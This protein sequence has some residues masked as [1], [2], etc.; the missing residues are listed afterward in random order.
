MTDDELSQK[1]RA[2]RPSLAFPADFQREIW[3]RIEAS[4][5]GTSDPLFTRLMGWLAQPVPAFALLVFMGGMG[6]LLGLISQRSGS[7]AL[8]EQGYVK[9]VSPFAAAHLSLRK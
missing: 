5:L 8:A 6:C 1:L 7:V 9:S 3:G 4:E 2:A